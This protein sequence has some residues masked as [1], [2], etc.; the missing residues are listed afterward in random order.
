LPGIGPLSGIS[1]LLLRPSGSTPPRSVVMLPGI[2][3]GSQYGGLDHFHLERLPGE[4]GLA[5]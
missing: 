1:I 5:H 2:Y 4:A 3:Y